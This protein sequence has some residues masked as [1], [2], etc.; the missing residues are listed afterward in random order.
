MLEI[1]KILS[2]TWKNRATRESL[3]TPIMHLVSIHPLRASGR[4]PQ[5]SPVSWNSQPKLRESCSAVPSRAVWCM[6]FFGMQPTLTHVP[7]RPAGRA[8]AEETSG[9]ARESHAPGCPPVSGRAGVHRDSPQVIP[10]GVGTTK[11]STITFFPSKAASCG[12]Q[13]HPL[14]YPPGT[15][16]VLLSMSMCST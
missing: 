14:Y 9:Q 1:F 10:L 13:P 16:D 6:S 12:A 5:H 8:N 3:V 7:P 2:F 15:I 11:S 4:P